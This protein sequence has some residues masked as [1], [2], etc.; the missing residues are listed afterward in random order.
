M[1]GFVCLYVT[2]C[3]IAVLIVLKR[4]GFGSRFA[5]VIWVFGY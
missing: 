1:G 4:R 5:E 3:G 2:V